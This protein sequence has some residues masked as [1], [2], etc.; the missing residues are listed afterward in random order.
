MRTMSDK[1]RKENY[2]ERTW[3][4]LNPTGWTP[5]SKAGPL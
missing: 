4:W 2:P 5:R 1:L 3:D